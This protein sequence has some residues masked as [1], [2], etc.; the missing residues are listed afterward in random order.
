LEELTALWNINRKFLEKWQAVKNDYFFTLEGQEREMGLDF[1]A[2]EAATDFTMAVCL[3]EEII[4]RISVNH[5]LH[6]NYSTGTLGYWISE[7]QNG[8]G[9]GTTA[10]MLACDFAFNT[11]NL[12]RLQAMIMPANLSSVAVVERLKFRYEG[13]GKSIIKVN[14]EWEDHQIFAITKEEWR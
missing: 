12:H 8:K 14:G 9:H 1:E 6:G 2:E 10:V 3:E 4:G 5:V 7:T 13:T 11:L